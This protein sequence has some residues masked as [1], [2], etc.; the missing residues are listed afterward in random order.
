MFS[1][2]WKIKSGQFTAACRLKLS[3]SLSVSILHRNAPYISWPN[4]S[5]IIAFTH[6]SSSSWKLSVVISVVKNGE[7]ERRRVFFTTLFWLTCEICWSIFSQHLLTLLNPHSLEVG[8][9]QCF[10]ST[11]AALAV[12]TAH[13]SLSRP[14]LI[15]PWVRVFIKIRVS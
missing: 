9:G 10:E 8:W 11:F 3:L 6:Q 1:Y 2:S 14:W 12:T 7:E 15:M 4:Q 13:I 5:Y